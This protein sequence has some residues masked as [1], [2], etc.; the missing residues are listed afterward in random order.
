MFI[1]IVYNT[2]TD[3]YVLWKRWGKIVT[4]LHTALPGI[5]GSG[6]PIT[7]AASAYQDATNNIPHQ[8]KPEEWPPC[9]EHKIKLCNSVEEWLIP[10][11]TFKITN[12]TRSLMSRDISCSQ[13]RQ[14]TFIWR[15]ESD[16]N[17]CRF[18]Q[19][20]QINTAV[21]VKAF[22]TDMGGGL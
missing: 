4:G 8:K 7:R 12:C 20:T 3:I 11:E 9:L 15:L 2:I 17:C 5:Q 21:R 10:S 6:L 13:M 19:L 16:S 14:I 22:E 18:H 1:D